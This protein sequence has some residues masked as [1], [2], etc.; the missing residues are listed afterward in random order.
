MSLLRY[1]PRI[2]PGTICDEF[3]T[4]LEI[5]PTLLCLSGVEPPK[6]VKLDGF[7]MLPVL[8]GESNSQRTE[9]YWKRKDKEAARV[10]QWKW[11]RNGNETYLFDLSNDLSERHNL[12]DD[13]PQKATELQKKFE[14]WLHETMVEAI[15]RG[16]FKDY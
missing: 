16:P 1:P 4:S 12:A 10:N 8:A 13:M 2:Q 5:L 15:P 9:M 3:L 11:I 7:D 14:A 6:G